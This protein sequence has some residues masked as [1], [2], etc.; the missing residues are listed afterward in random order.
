MQCKFYYIKPKE[1]WSDFYASYDNMK[2]KSDTDAACIK[3]RVSQVVF[4][5]EEGLWLLRQWM[6]FWW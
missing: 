4:L 1:N 6:L 3:A 5:L 2:P